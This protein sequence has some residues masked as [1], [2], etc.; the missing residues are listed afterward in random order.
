MAAGPLPGVGGLAHRMPPPDRPLRRLFERRIVIVTGK[1]GVGKTAVSL[2]LGVLAARRGLNTLVCETSGADQVCARF[3][4]PAGGYAVTALGPRLSTMS[5]APEAAIEEYLLRTLRFRKLYEMVFKNRVM[6]PF[7]DAVPG[8]HDLIQLGKVFD[9]ERERGPVL[10]GRSRQWDLVVI[11]APATGHGISM[12]TAPRGMMRLT[13]SGPFHD[14]ARDVAGLIE[15]PARTAIVLVSLAEA[16]PVHET[17]ELHG[18]LGRFQEQVAGVVLNG[19]RQHGLPDAF[20]ALRPALAAG[21]NAAGHDALGLADRAIERAAMQD[22]AR[23]SLGR[24]GLPLVDLPD[25]PVSTLGPQQ[26][27]QL[28]SALEASL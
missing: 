28:A 20:H 19:V 8:L 14:N 4:L 18:R 7:L 15:D 10:G 26:F 1:G 6:G 17:A 16:L 3:G 12:L 2:A 22:R 11:D 25:L 13:R 5:I 21:A 23:Q 9:L 27:E 24:L